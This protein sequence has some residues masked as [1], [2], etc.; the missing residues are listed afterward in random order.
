MRLARIDIHSFVTGHSLRLPGREN[1]LSL[2]DEELTLVLA[3]IKKKHKAIRDGRIK[4]CIAEG[5]LVLTNKGL[6]PVERISVEHRLWDGVEWVTHDGVVYTGDRE[7]ITYGGLTATQNHEVYTQS[8]R[9][10]PFGE[11]ARL[12]ERLEVTGIGRQEVRQRESY[13]CGDQAF[14]EWA[15]LHQGSVYPLQKEEV[16]LQR[17]PPQWALNRVLHL[18]SFYSI[19]R[20]AWKQIRC[21]DSA[22]QQS[23]RSKLQTLW[24]AWNQSPVPIPQTVYRMGCEELAASQLSWSGNRQDRQQWALR[25]GE[26]ETVYQTRANVEQAEYPQGLVDGGDYHR[27]ELSDSLYLQLDIQV[28]K[29]GSDWRTNYQG[30]DG[31][32]S[33]QTQELAR[34]RGTP[35]RVRVYDILN[36]GPRHR[37]TV[38]GKLVGNSTHGRQFGLGPMKFFDMNRESFNSLKEVKELFALLDDLFPRVFVDYPK[39]VR[40]Q[41]H[42]S[43]YLL[44]RYG[45][46]RW[47][48]EVYKY[49]T[50]NGGWTLGEDAEAALSFFP[51]NDAF[52]MA[53]DALLDVNRAGSDQKY[54]LVNYVHD[55]LVFHCPESLIEAC[56][57]DIRLIM[58]KPSQKLRSPLVPDGLICQVDAGVGGD[59]A[60]VEGMV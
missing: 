36:A 19:L 35:Q 14:R 46:I 37:F 49:D 38:S 11:A 47:F 4:N 8:G 9:Q 23:A 58:E 57:A 56:V 60:S 3:D 53:R 34:S 20:S 16:D 42:R 59:L 29:E 12:L 31:I 40:D 32:G 17:Q 21:G 18:H 7:V 41:A 26:F 28:G 48:W 5:Q 22:L 44:S 51:S 52:G 55:E 39:R 1:W 30:G 15:Y 24:G 6:I 2:P 45:Y 43:H 27:Y 25:A 54:E 13:I 50:R 10:I 33:S